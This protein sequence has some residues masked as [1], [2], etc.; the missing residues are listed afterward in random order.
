MG[1]PEREVAH[2]IRPEAARGA[3]RRARPA[4]LSD[5]IGRVLEDLGIA[6][7]LERAR[8]AAEWE[9]I[10]GPHIS[11]VTRN[12]RVRGRTL[13]VEV[14]SAAWSMELNMM[15][16]QLLEQLN[17]RLETQKIDRIVFVQAGGDTG[18]E[19]PD[20]RRKTQGRG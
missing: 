13:F 18:P 12:A 7:R 5:L 20:V 16:R 11:R 1:N 2:V 10:V 17:R 19:G 6:G 14:D 3:G 15:R 8:A 9:A 4:P